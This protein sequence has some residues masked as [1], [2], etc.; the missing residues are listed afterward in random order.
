MKSIENY[1]KKLEHLSPLETGEKT[2]IE[3]KGEIK[4]VIFDIYGTLVISAS[5]DIDKVDVKTQSLQQAMKQAGFKT[6]TL[7]EE[8]YDTLLYLFKETIKESHKASKGFGIPFPEI[9]ITSIWKAVFKKYDNDKIISETAD[10]TTMAFI[11]ELL[12]N[13]VFPMPNMIETLKE[14]KKRK[15]PL[16]IVSNA[17]FY[18]PIMMN[19][20]IDG[21]YTENEFISG[22]EKNLHVYSYKE[23]RAKPDYSIFEKL[24]PVLKE[25]Y[26]ISP[27]EVVF[28]GNDMLNDI[29]TASKVGFKTALFAGDKRSLRLRQDKTEVSGITPDYIITD[30]K[31][32][33]DII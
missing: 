26:S 7:K 12:S 5:G 29:Y 14:L 28:V 32:L 4:S 33:L 19:Y 16:G 2:K 22:F 31:Q 20:F 18:T 6:E 3:K 11:F 17:Q 1:L 27:N 13:K 25:R 9:E 10:I 24:L 8:D 21:N 23:K 15:I 30:L